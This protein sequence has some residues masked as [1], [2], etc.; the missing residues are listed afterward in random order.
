MIYYSC[1]LELPAG[2][3]SSAL[4]LMQFR[5]ETCGKSAVSIISRIHLA[6]QSQTLTRLINHIGAK[7]FSPVHISTSNTHPTPLNE[8]L[9]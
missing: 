4:L 9:S 3:R 5:G 8:R 7:L 2:V 1:C 6:E